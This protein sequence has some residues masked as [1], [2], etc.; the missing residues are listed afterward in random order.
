MSAGVRLPAYTVL[1]AVA[2]AVAFLVGC[3][4]QTPE[5]RQAGAQAV[6]NGLRCA[7]TVAVV[8][9]GANTDADKA[10]AAAHAV[11]TAQACDAAVTA[12]LSAV[13]A[14]A[15]AISGENQ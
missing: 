12:G 4:G 1:P 11:T 8:A 2:L 3:A 7:V 5:Q 10:I 14:G 13:P 15:M 9:G 6:A